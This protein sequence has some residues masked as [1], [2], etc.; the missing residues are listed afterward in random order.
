MSWAEATWRGAA[1]GRWV[2]R[3]GGTL[4]ALFLSAFVFGEGPPPVWRLGALQNL[5]FLGLCAL[6][7]G[8]LI[9]WKWEFWGGAVPLAGYLLLGSLNPRDFGSLLL[10]LPAGFGALY[11][12][13]WARRR[14]GAPAAGSAWQVPKRALAIAGAAVGVFV[15]LC[16]NEMF[17]NPPLMTPAFRASPALAG[18]WRSPLTSTLK[19]PPANRLDAA[20]IVG[21]DG[22]LSGAIGGARITGRIANNRSWFG[23]L[24]SWR[25][26]YAIRGALSQPASPYRD[27]AAERFTGLLGA[28]GPNLEGVL[29]LAN[30]RWRVRFVKQ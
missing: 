4:M 11:L 15:L 21:A 22:S 19:T 30:R 14:A 17:G 10:L 26:D 3:V 16:A 27:A 25:E 9:G 24:M 5:H 28:R 1:V 12:L 7:L 2:A 23:R 13:C 20:L 8:L 29:L 6:F 18:E